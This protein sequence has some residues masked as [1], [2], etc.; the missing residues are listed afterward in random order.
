MA[1]LGLFVLMIGL[2]AV[3]KIIETWNAMSLYRIYWMHFL[4]IRYVKWI[5]FTNELAGLI[6]AT[7]NR[8]GFSDRTHRDK[9]I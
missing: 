1:V 6:I 8:Q 7:Q 5:N 4:S 2:I 9:T 3:Y